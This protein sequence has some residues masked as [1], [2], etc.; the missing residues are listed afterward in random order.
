M[1]L[2]VLLALI[3]L[4]IMIIWGWQVQVFRGKE[5]KNNDGS[6]DNNKNNN[7]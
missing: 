7:S 1:I 4:L 2:Y 5:M 6:A 3:G